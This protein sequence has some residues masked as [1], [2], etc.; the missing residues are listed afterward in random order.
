MDSIFNI[1]KNIVG[2]HIPSIINIWDLFFFI[3]DVFK[4]VG[5]L[6]TELKVSSVELEGVSSN[7]K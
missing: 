5:I 1:I 7:I 6:S 3:S 2:I 4:V